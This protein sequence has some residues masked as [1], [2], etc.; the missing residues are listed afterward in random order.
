[1]KKKEIHRFSIDLGKCEIHYD[2]DIMKALDIT[3]RVPE[4]FDFTDIDGNGTFWKIEN[5]RLIIYLSGPIDN[6][7]YRGRLKSIS[8][9]IPELEV[10]NYDVNSPSG[11]YI[12]LVHA[13]IIGF[14]PKTVG[15]STVVGL[16]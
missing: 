6:V 8:G 15:G 2:N 13:D 4:D 10:L 11:F 12:Q 5:R 14:L 16:G 9:H 7:A 1:M 3:I